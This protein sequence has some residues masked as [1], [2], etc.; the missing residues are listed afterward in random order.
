M[1]GMNRK[2]SLASK[3]HVLGVAIAG[4]ALAACVMEAETRYSDNDT[5][6]AYILSGYAC[7]NLHY[8]GDWISDS[9]YAELPFLPAGTPIKVKSIS[10]Y[11]VYV[12]VEGRPMRM[13]LDYGRVQETTEQWVR[14]VVVA[15]DPKPK[16][17]SYSPSVREAIR[18]SR[19]MR[20][21]TKEQS[22]LSVGYPQT[23]ENPRLD[24]PFWRYWRSSFAPY[25]V[26]WSNNRIEKID[27]DT[28]TL[29]F[30]T[31]TGR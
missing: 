31:Y 18:S 22:I 8:E 27:A 5:T 16:I 9:N 2:E 29:S 21:M 11:R 17:A 14:K 20:G 4:T 30:I 24:V 19:L 3:L 13:G 23:D 7:C 15:E 10:G 12:D 26:H 6:S 28:D 1:R 25:S